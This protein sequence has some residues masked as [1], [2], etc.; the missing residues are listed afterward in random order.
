M[1]HGLEEVPIGFE[2]D[3]TRSL[4]GK[5]SLRFIAMVEERELND[6]RLRL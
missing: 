2:N 4:K 6:Q 3:L 1:R 5:S